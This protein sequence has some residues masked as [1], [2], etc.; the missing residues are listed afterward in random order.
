MQKNWKKLKKTKKQQQQEAH[1]PQWL[2]WV[3]SYKNFIQQFSPSVAMATNQNEE[4]AQNY[5]LGRRLLNK[6]F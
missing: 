3:N 5:M 2:T 6:R 4:F 1:G